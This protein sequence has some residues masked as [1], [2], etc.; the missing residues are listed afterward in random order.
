MCYFKLDYYEIAQEIL[1]PFLASYPNSFAGNNL[2]CSILSRL[3]SGKAAEQEMKKYLNYCP[4]A[5][6]I[7]K[8]VFK[9][10]MVHAE[11]FKEYLLH[12]IFFSFKKK[13]RSNEYFS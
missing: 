10:N 5:A 11:I 7:G 6:K 12:F 13:Q 2:R 3:Y 8:E 9:H 4:Q 1:D